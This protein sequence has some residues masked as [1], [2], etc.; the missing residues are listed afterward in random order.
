MM[1]TEEQIQ[2]LFTFCEKHFVKYYDVQVELVDHLANAI[3]IEMRADPLLTFEKAVEK[4]Y[5]S[6]GY[7][8]FQPLVNEKEKMAE[9]QIKILFWKLFKSH[10][11]W[12][13]VLFFLLLLTIFLALFSFDIIFI[14]CFLAATIFLGL[15]VALYASYFEGFMSV[16]EKKFLLINFS[17]I[18]FLIGA[19][20]CLLYIQGLTGN[21]SFLTHTPLQILIPGISILLSLNIILIIAACQ[22]LNS[23][24]RTLYKNYPEVFQPQNKHALL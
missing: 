11:G 24:K 3:E 8:G 23:I 17:R 12:P 2:S 15:G 9:K 1:L 14:K 22:T 10:F 5:R 18:S 19:L 16:T 21:K 6:F 7:G 20:P 4:I 13:K